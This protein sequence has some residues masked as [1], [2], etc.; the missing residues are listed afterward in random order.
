[1]KWAGA[2]LESWVG[3][4]LGTRLWRLEGPGAERGRA[5][6]RDQIATM[7]MAGDW[8]VSGSWKENMRTSPKSRQIRTQVLRQEMG[9]NPCPVVR[10]RSASSQWSAQSLSQLLKSVPWWCHP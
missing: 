3:L 6:L 9:G 1:M 10:R 7:D 2:K 5:I 8:E 4:R